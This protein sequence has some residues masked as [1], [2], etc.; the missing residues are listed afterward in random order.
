MKNE[1]LKQKRKDMGLSQARLAELIGVTRQTINLIEAGKYNP[2]IK[3]C[4]EICYALDSSL[5]EL[6]WEEKNE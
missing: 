6:F 5:D 1:V 2:S 4:L 3:L